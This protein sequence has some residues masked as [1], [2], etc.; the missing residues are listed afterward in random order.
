MLD[1]RSE[2]EK[3][4]FHKKSFNKFKKFFISRSALA[5]ADP[6]IS[7]II[8]EIYG[9]DAE[10]K[11]ENARAN[12]ELIKKG[13]SGLQERWRK[14][15]VA[16]YSA[17]RI[18]VET[19]APNNLKFAARSDVTA[20][21]VA[22]ILKFV[23]AAVIERND[24]LTIL[25]QGII[26]E[27]EE[28]CFD[29]N[30]Y[31]VKTIRQLHRI[32]WFV[33]QNEK[34][35][36]E[37]NRRK[38]STRRKKRFAAKNLLNPAFDSKNLHSKTASDSPDSIAKRADVWA[39]ELGK[40]IVEGAA[41]GEFDFDDELVAEEI[42]PQ[43]SAA[44][45]KPFRVTHEEMSWGRTRLTDEMLGVVWAWLK[46][47]AARKPESLEW[48]ATLAFIEL[49]ILF[50]YPPEF[51][52]TAEVAERRREERFENSESIANG[53]GERKLKVSNRIESAPVLVYEY[54]FMRIR[55]VRPGKKSAFGLPLEEN[56]EENYLASSCNYIVP[57]PDAI[58]SSL[59]KLIAAGDDSTDE[60][61]NLLFSFFSESS[62]RTVHLTEKYLNRILKALG[63]SINEKIT[64]EK[65]A[66]SARTLLREDGTLSN[67]QIALMSGEIRYG[68]ASSMFY[69]NFKVLDLLKKYTR[70]I[71]RVLSNLSIESREFIERYDRLEINPLEPSSVEDYLIDLSKVDANARVGSPFVFKSEKFADYLKNLYAGAQETSD[72]VLRHN[73][74]TAFAALS[75]MV[76]TGIRP[77]EL[78]FIT[79]GSL[80]LSSSRPTLSVIAKINQ[81][82]TEWRTLEISTEAAELL[83]S[84]QSFSL[85]TRRDS[86]LLT[87]FTRSEIDARLGNS[88]F[89]YLRRS[90][91]PVRLTTDGLSELVRNLSYL[92][93]PRYPWRLNSPRHFYRT[94]TMEIDVPEKIV[95]S[96][97]G[98]QTTGS[99]SLGLFS[100]YDRLEEISCAGSISGYIW[101]KLNMNYVR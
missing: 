5:F 77:L 100:A 23:P 69:S 22:T 15:C 17:T 32:S 79:D 87:E 50:G 40:E 46:T 53:S 33:L 27:C 99:E 20:W 45:S 62:G 85:A 91:S 28:L 35:P 81:K 80:N 94:T 86:Y 58:T 14:I 90:L 44:E 71:E 37:T 56:E 60:R 38:K 10:L 82:H 47:Q 96:L 36:W 29:Y 11:P 34:Y 26:N 4:I 21:T 49:L 24:V 1:E 61:S 78:S 2:P 75:L 89:F 55:P 30:R 88:L 64:V 16:G 39:D 76:L 93:L 19:P 43:G 59:N 52:L 31:E 41:P 54:G 51:L 92:E 7:Q 97:L 9:A 84:Y 13:F 65:L 95:N 67:L 8:T 101:N 25:T 98:H 42:A 72:F 6:V 68:V 66:K 63:E 18:A 48:T 74:M 12:Y 83:Q 3:Q 70:S 57:L 73:R